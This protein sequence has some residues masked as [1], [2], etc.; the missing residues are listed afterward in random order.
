MYAKVYHRRRSAT[1]EDISRYSEKLHND[2]L[3]SKS[4][5][6]HTRQNQFKVYAMSHDSGMAV[7]SGVKFSFADIKSFLLLLL[8][9]RKTTEVTDSKTNMFHGNKLK[10]E[11]E[12]FRALCRLL[13]EH[14]RQLCKHSATTRYMKMIFPA[15]EYI[16][17]IFT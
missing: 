6:Q 7:H 3:S 4:V 9:K 13:N 17:G 11:Q 8:C 10:L 15:S 5:E 12:S 1:E 2:Y 16:L 14:L